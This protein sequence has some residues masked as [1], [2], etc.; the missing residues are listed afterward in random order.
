M[1]TTK[2]KVAFGFGASGEA[3]TNWI[4]NSLAFFFYN[5]ILGLSGTL[6]ALAVGI[7]IAFDAVSDPLIG[8]ISDRFRSSLGRRH[9][10]MYAAPVPLVISI[11]AM[12]HAPVDSSQI[13]LFVWFTFWTVAMRASSTLFAV[14]HLALGAELSAD[15]FERTRVMSF[16]N[17]LYFAGVIVMHSVVWF[18]VFPQYAD[19]RMDQAAYFPIVIFCCTLVLMAMFS[20]AFGT[21]KSSP[22]NLP[23]IPLDFGRNG[24][25]WD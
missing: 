9:P 23:Q 4:F 17:L 13:Q 21:Q 12:F 14:P 16:N 22:S 18:V 7:G 10:L 5:Q 11:F 8:S 19:G 15:Y 6:T 2:T 20:S 3:A 1:L 24:T 25:F